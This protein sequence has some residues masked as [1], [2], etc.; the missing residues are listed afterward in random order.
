M[1]AWGWTPR[2]HERTAAQGATPRRRAG[3]GRRELPLRSSV[4]ASA[5]GFPRGGGRA[6]ALE[7]DPKAPGLPA[8]GEFA[9]FQGTR[10][11]RKPSE[12]PGPEPTAARSRLEGLPRTSPEAR[13]REDVGASVSP[14]GSPCKTA[15]RF[16]GQ[17]LGLVGGG[18]R[19]ACGRRSRVRAFPD[20]GT[21]SLIRGF[22]LPE[23]RRF[24]EEPGHR[25][26]DPFPP[27][28]SARRSRRARGPDH[29]GADMK[30]ARSDRSGTSDRTGT[31]DR[32]WIRRRGFL[33]ARAGAPFHAKLLPAELP[34]AGAG[35]RRDRT[36]PPARVRSRTQPARRAGR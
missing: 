11:H 8:L 34:S 1:A 12:S 30:R 21:A 22:T 28:G 24:H 14:R 20:G 23:R 5:S 3:S 19:R 10:R 27:C 17:A 18:L 25:S 26:L 32:A 6:F 35:S 31:S 2:L 9:I 16:L 13:R 7:P 4:C 36:G 33:R 29:E 15:Q